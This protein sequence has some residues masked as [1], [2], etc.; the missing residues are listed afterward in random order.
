MFKKIFILVFT[1]FIFVSCGNPQSNVG[2]G[3]DVDLTKLNATLAYAEV[4]NML[5]TPKD[6]LGKMIKVKG[7]VY[8]QPDPSTGTVDRFVIIQDVQSCCVQGL[9]FRFTDESHGYPKQDE[10]IEIVGEFKGYVED[11][12][13][14][15]YLQVN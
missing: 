3:V 6:Y 9:E 5:T 2:T 8:E 7:A 15:Y 12:T 4:T 1:C 11:L 13:T 10:V 14:Y